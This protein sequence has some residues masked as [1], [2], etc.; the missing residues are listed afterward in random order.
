LWAAHQGVLD[1]SSVSTD[2]P[3]IALILRHGLD[4][5]VIQISAAA[6]D[7]ILAL[8]SGACLGLAV[9][10]ASAADANFDPAGVLGLLLQ[11]KAITALDSPRRNP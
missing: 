8:Q 6:G 11:K 5:E 7:F 1:I 2:A 10:A 9:E 4:V 3:E